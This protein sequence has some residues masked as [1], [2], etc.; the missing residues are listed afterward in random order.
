MTI[1]IF[2]L[3]HIVR[4]IMY[5]VMGHMRGRYEIFR[6]HKKLRTIANIIDIYWIHMMHDNTIKNLSIADS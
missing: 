1:P 2:Q 6:I 3:E 5:C 4:A